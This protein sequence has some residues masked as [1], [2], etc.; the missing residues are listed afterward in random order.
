MFS[1]FFDLLNTTESEVTVFAPTTAAFD[2][3]STNV[4]D[5]L[6]NSPDPGMTDNLIGF[7][8]VNGTVRFNDIMKKTRFDN[9]ADSLLHGTTIFQFTYNPYQSYGLAVEVS[10]L[11]QHTH[12]P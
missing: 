12:P 8:I 9:L 5:A 11:V 3:Q 6:V 2:G 7:H 1:S 10:L 4:I